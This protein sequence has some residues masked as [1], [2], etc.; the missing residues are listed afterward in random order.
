[1][2]LCALQLRNILQ[3]IDLYLNKSGKREGENFLITI[4]TFAFGYF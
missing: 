1:M 2:L 3:H 4:V